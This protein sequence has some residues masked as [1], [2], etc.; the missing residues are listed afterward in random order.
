MSV[1]V[2]LSALCAKVRSSYKFN[3]IFNSRLALLK[4]LSLLKGLCV[5]LKQLVAYLIN[6]NLLLACRA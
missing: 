2:P 5:L 6:N 3:V 4:R 1:V